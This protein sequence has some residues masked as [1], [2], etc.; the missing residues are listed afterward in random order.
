[1]SGSCPFLKRNHGF[2]LIQI[3]ILLAAASLAMVATL[4][5]AKLRPVTNDIN[6]AKLANIMNALRQFEA[7]NGR[8]PCPADA[9]KPQG[10]STYGLEA[11]S[12]GS[13]SNCGGTPAANLVDSTNGVAIGMVPVRT[14]G[15]SMNDALDGYGHDITYAVD[16]SA[17]GCWA[18]QGLMGKLK[19]VDS[20]G[21]ALAASDV[22]LN[23][24]AALVSHGADGHGAWLPLPGGS[25][26]ASRLNSGVTSDT[27]QLLNAH[28]TSGFAAMTSSLGSNSLG[29]SVSFVKKTTGNTYDD[30][31][32]FQ[33][34]Y[35]MLNTLPQS[36]TTATSVSSYPANGTYTLGN[37]LQ[38]V[39]TFPRAATIV[40]GQP[41]LALSAITTTTPS[42]SI[43]TGNVAYATYAS[44]SGTTQLTFNYPV[45]ATDYAPNGITLASPVNM[46]TG[47]NTA[48]INPCL[49]FF[50]SPDLSGVLIQRSTMIYIADP[51]NNNIQAF[52]TSGTYTLG[53]GS[54]GS[55]TSPRDVAVDASGNLWVVDSGNNRVQEYSSSG[56]WKGQVGGKGSSCTTSCGCFTSSG[57][58]PGSFGSG[59]GQLYSPAG[60]AVDPTTGY[61][62]VADLL[63]N[64]LVAY[65][66]SGAWK[67]NIGGTAAACAGTA[68]ACACTSGSC[69]S[70]S[71]SGNGQLNRPRALAIDASGNIWVADT[72]NNRI[73]EFTNTGTWLQSIGGL[74]TSCTSCG[75]TTAGTACPSSAGYNT[76]DLG[77]PYGVAID[78]SNGY[79]WASNTSYGSVMVYDSTGTY[80][81][82][83]G[84][85]GTNTVFSPQ[86]IAFDNTVSPPTAWVVDSGN[87]RIM[88]YTHTGT[89]QASIGGTSS[90]C[91][92]CICTSGTCPSSYGSGTGQ[93]SGPGGL[94]ITR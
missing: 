79:V 57:S 74:T 29:T 36:V 89:W 2:S 59:T 52:T 65:D 76:G 26:T 75:C 93:L 81:F 6:R 70:S 13:Y 56:V 28:I 68:G 23:S 41:R 78:P 30:T 8:L 87:N 43:G 73:V 47:S 18:S 5:S 25:G 63:N 54:Y 40:T 91:S 90:S 85:S 67:M 22:T 84:T 49:T 82:T 92:S 55:P 3:S 31:V 16:T 1:M 37:T 62:W 7:S 32:L 20:A 51:S 58:C 19:I 21:T 69:P 71:G 53:F 35:G 11:G 46:N 24:V 38:F 15:L 88:K 61:I 94:S 45:L 4:P 77:G 9:S 50:S 44:G 83:V 10:S 80:K 64:R 60:V 17:S 14:L 48:L 33:S 72:S 12:P 66:S 27:D 86:Q 34:G 39:L 42:A